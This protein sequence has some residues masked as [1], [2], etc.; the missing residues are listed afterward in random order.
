MQKVISAGGWEAFVTISRLCL[1]PPASE[2]HLPRAGLSACSGLRERFGDNALI[3]SR[4][5]HGC[6]E[7]IQKLISLLGQKEREGA[8]GAVAKDDVIRTAAQKIGQKDSASCRT[9]RCAGRHV[10]GGQMKSATLLAG[11]YQDD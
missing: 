3:E 8:C 1:T 10:E 11:E 4:L 7:V 6:A 9:I 5:A 2:S